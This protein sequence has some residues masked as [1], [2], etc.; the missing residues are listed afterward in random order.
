MPKIEE[1]SGLTFNVQWD[2]LAFP[3]PKNVE[4]KAA[5]SK[6]ALSETKKCLQNVTKIHSDVKI[7]SGYNGMVKI[8]IESPE[9]QVSEKTELWEE[10][11]NILVLEKEV[12][13]IT[14]DVNND[15]SEKVAINKADLVMM[16]WHTGYQ[17]KGKETLIYHK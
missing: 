14:V 12:Q 2:L 5:N 7:I 11:F 6:K 17:G 13:H 3:N 10:I 4:H 15:I 16:P 9:S 8:I 1:P